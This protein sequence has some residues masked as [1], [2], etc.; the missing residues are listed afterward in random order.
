MTEP[1]RTPST[2]AIATENKEPLDEVVGR[3]NPGDRELL[4]LRMNLELSY[5]EIGEILD[6]AESTVKSRMYSL[7]ARM[8]RDLQSSPVSKERGTLEQCERT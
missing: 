5:R 7:L 2:D 8:R 1:S 6:T 3:L 4:L